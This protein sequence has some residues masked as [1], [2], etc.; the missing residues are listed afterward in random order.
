MRKRRVKPYRVKSVLIRFATGFDNVLMMR[1]PILAM[2]L[3]QARHGRY[4]YEY[5]DEGKR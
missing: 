3:V 5:D 1:L 2:L 4:R